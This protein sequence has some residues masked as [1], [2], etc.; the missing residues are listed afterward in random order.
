MPLRPWNTELPEGLCVCQV[1]LCLCLCVWVH[2]CLSDLG[3]LSSQRLRVSVSSVSVFVTWV[4]L[5]PW[6]TELPDLY[7]CVY[8]LPAREV[9][10]SVFTNRKSLE[11]I[12]VGNW[13]QS[14]FKL[15]GSKWVFWDMACV[16]PTR[17][18]SRTWN[19][20]QLSRGHNSR[21]GFWLKKAFCGNVQLLLHS[22]GMRAWEVELPIDSMDFGTCTSHPISLKYL[23]FPV[24]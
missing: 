15:P 21:Q 23:A 11:I 16:C 7:V 19:S 5:K 9:G 14:V 2:G 17:C 6:N 18:H 3:T 24:G 1:C 10:V 12:S 20:L 13:N 22:G 4:P 8:S